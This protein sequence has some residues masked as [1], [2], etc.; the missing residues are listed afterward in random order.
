MRFLD[1]AGSGNGEFPRKNGDLDTS[2]RG[3]TGYIRIRNQQVSGSSPLAGSTRINNLRRSRVQT[4]PTHVT[5]VSPPIRR[6]FGFATPTPRRSTNSS[7]QPAHSTRGQPSPPPGQVRGW[8]PT[9]CRACLTYRRT[10]CPPTSTGRPTD[11]LRLFLLRWRAFRAAIGVQADRQIRSGCSSPVRRRV[12]S[13]ARPRARRAPSP[14]AW[15][16]DTQT[17]PTVSRHGLAVDVSGERSGRPV[18]GSPRVRMPS[19]PTPP[20]DPVVG[21]DDVEACACC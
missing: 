20:Q 10:G 8:R 11:P 6:W 5:T 18:R 12:A 16:L 3:W 13:R 17:G 21:R 15:S 1:V 4:D 9:A 14:A 7:G 2:G 19:N